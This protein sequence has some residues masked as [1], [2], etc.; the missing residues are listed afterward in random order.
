MKELSEKGEEGVPWEDGP[1]CS[2]VHAVFVVSSAS[3]Y[4]VQNAIINPV[5]E[6]RGRRCGVPSEPLEQSSKGCFD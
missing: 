5:R 1:P 3:W 4:V 2:A 6:G